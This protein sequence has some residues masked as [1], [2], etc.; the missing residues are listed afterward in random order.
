VQGLEQQHRQ[1]VDGY[2]DTLSPDQLSA[3]RNSSLTSPS[4]NPFASSEYSR[5]RMPSTG[6]IP[7]P[8]GSSIRPR[9][10]GSLELAPNEHLPNV[11]ADRYRAHAKSLAHDINPRPAKRQR[12]DDHL[13]PSSL[14][15]SDMQKYYEQY[16]PQFA[17]LPDSEKVKTIASRADQPLEQALSVAVQLLPDLQFGTTV[18]G[19]HDSALE[20]DPDTANHRKRPSSARF[21]NY[22][23]LEEYLAQEI[24]TSP[25]Q[26]SDEDNLTLLWT[27]L[28]T[29]FCVD[30][31]LG[32]LKDGN[33]SRSRQLLVSR[34]ILDH[35]RL[36]LSQMSAEI[37]ADRMN[38]ADEINQAYACTTMLLKYQALSLGLSPAAF[39]PVGSANIVRDFDAKT[40][41]PSAA[42]LATSSN[43]L[44]ALSDMVSLGDLDL[45][46]RNAIKKA[47]I[48][49]FDCHFANYDGH[50]KDDLLV[51]QVQ[52]FVMLCANAY[53]TSLPIFPTNLLN[54]ADH[55]ASIL[56]EEAKNSVG[57]RHYNPIDMYTWTLTALIFCEFQTDVSSKTLAD[58]A[59]SRLRELRVELEKK[60]QN[61]HQNYPY[62]AFF[63]GTVEYWVDAVL[64]MIDY[65]LARPRA[66]DEE[67]GDD[68]V[69]V[70]R[71]A[72]WL[73]RG[74]MNAVLFFIK[75]K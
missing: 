68:S 51:K 70:P 35:L 37:Q 42:F 16:H 33:L 39:A 14:D 7:Y 47:T 25:E 74:W 18:N 66:A 52:R 43:V 12:T 28:L 58:F 29:A 61:F 2:A 24:V 21:E 8:T 48:D 64:G 63:G 53:E 71:F 45:R 38:Y 54:H 73:E 27:L 6:W 65:V 3:T 41:P 5:D 72:G 30:N 75:K 31:N 1:S 55:L 32:T 15:D 34:F 20:V 40:L 59:D 56:I 4:V 57:S 22:K 62:K 44:S 60:S 26:R 46:A 49:L 9:N 67:Q 17:L 11:Q 13:R 50:V 23:A 36:D 19:H 10:V 69:V